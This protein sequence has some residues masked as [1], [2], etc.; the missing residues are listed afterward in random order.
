LIEESGNLKIT[1]S[2]IACSPEICPIG[3]VDP[4]GVLTPPLGALFR[5]NVA[6]ICGLVLKEP[7]PI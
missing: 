3:L 4:V 6:K 7:L 5:T 2:A 1:R